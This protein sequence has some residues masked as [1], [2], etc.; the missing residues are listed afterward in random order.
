MLR[1]RK[2]PAIAPSRNWRLAGD[3]C[4]AASVAM[5]EVQKPVLWAHDSSC[6]F[7]APTLS[8]MRKPRAAT[9]CQAMGGRR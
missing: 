7:P 4:G 6:I 9:N 3:G 5:Y 2:L 1:G 8:A